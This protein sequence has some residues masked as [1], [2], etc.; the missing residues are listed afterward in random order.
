[1]SSFMPTWTQHKWPSDSKNPKDKIRQNS[2][3]KWPFGILLIYVCWSLIANFCAEKRWRFKEKRFF[4]RWRARAPVSPVWESDYLLVNYFLSKNRISLIHLSVLGGLLFWLWVP[5]DLWESR[6]FL[7]STHLTL[8]LYSNSS[9]Y[10]LN[11]SSKS[12]ARMQFRLMENCQ[13]N[14]TQLCILG[15]NQQLDVRLNSV[16]NSGAK[17]S[18]TA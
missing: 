18:F 6:F 12:N 3:L 8:L 13:K 17:Q 15:G 11:R 2:C 16:R 10:F 9:T 7:I 1:M 14:G 4:W 5:R